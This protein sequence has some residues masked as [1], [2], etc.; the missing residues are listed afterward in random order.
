MIE[1]MACGTPM[2]A[3]P[4]GSVPEIIEESTGFVVNDKEEAVRA[5]SRLDELD[6][7]A[8]RRRFEERFSARRMAHD[9]VAIYRKLAHLPHAATQKRRAPSATQAPDAAADIA[10]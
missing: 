7:G 9:Y 10:G 2:I 8:I 3:Y 1:A 6:R 5:V 4:E